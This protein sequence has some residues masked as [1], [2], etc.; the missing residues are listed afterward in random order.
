MLPSA[1]SGCP[2]LFVAILT[3]VSIEAC[4]LREEEEE[5]STPLSQ[6]AWCLGNRGP[7]PRRGEPYCHHLKKKGGAGISLWWLEFQT[8]VVEFEVL[9]GW[10]SC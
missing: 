8:F 5:E 3:K 9:S 7:V 2:F 1:K 4:L 6:R 10:F